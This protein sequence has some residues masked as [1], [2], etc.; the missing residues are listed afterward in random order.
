M[1]PRVTIGSLGPN[2]AT[3]TVAVER[4]V[5][6]YSSTT[7]ILP[8]TVREEHV[9]SHGRGSRILVAGDATLAAQG[10]VTNRGGLIESGEPVH[11]RTVARLR[12]LADADQR[13]N[14]GHRR[15]GPLA[16]CG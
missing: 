13:C 5:L 3:N 11:H 15:G 9:Q 1:V 4:E 16:L 2:Y 12:S 8:Q 6:P 14:R 7:L 10:T